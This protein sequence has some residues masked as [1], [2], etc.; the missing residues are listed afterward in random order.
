MFC[1]SDTGL[2]LI[3]RVVVVRRGRGGCGL[4]RRVLSVS[5]R[6]PCGRSPVSGLAHGCQSFRLVWVSCISPSKRDG[7]SGRRPCAD[8]Y[9]RVSSRHCIIMN[10]PPEGGGFAPKDGQQN[11]SNHHERR[12]AH[13]DSRKTNVSHVNDDARH[14]VAPGPTHHLL[15]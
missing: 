9:G 7:I 6:S 13:D 11:S 4:L 14:L 8:R 1:L 10:G 15:R 5:G 2:V 12:C 3:W